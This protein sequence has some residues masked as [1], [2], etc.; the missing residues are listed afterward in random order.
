MKFEIKT[1][2]ELNC[3]ELYKIIKARVDIFVVEQYCAY[4]E[5]D[6]KDYKSVHLF[7]KKDDKITAYL[8][9]IPAGISYDEPSIGRVLVDK[10]YRREG[11]A[12]KMMLK[13]LEYIENNFTD[14]NNGQDSVR[15]SAQK[16]LL[17]FYTSLGFKKVSEE[18]LEDGIP[19]Y[20]ML[21][22]Y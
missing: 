11:R 14:K 8:R 15:I 13:A 10:D 7:Q 21:Y 16:Y 6:N 2:E 18:Y 4:P 12:K 1:F 9:I 5:C 17:D 22:K 19:H 3:K 20:E